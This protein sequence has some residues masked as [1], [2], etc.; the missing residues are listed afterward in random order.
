MT[1]YRLHY[2]PESGNSAKLTF[3]TLMNQ[4]DILICPR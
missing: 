1:N 2:F 4:R 3:L